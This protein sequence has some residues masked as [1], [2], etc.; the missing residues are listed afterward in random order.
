MSVELTSQEKLDI[1][2]SHI[3]NLKAGKYNLELSLIEENSIGTPSQE[4]ISLYTNEIQDTDLRIAAL[5]SEI[6]KL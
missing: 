4:K 1:I 5:Q 2:N 6:D 3:K